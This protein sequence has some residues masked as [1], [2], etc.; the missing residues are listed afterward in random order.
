[1][2]DEKDE[3]KPGENPQIDKV[4]KAYL[5]LGEESLATDTCIAAL[6][7]MSTSDRSKADRMINM[8][9]YWL[10]K[11][12]ALVRMLTMQMRLF[13]NVPAVSLE[14]FSLDHPP[15][16]AI[17]RRANQSDVYQIIIENMPIVDTRMPWA[18]VMAFRNDPTSKQQLR[19][20]R[21]WIH[22][23]L[24]SKI[25]YLELKERIE[26]LLEA[27][28]QHLKG[29]GIKNGTSILKAFVVGSAEIAEAVIKLR[30]KTLAEMP[31]K[32]FEARTELVEAERN[33]PGRE[34][35]YIV[36]ATHE[37]S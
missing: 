11:D 31:F 12:A 26:F 19:E 23:V 24:D 25:T 28:R 30:L 14:T 20:L 9:R 33:A 35:A 8:F 4:L 18:E 17:D 3:L 6:D 16:N 13:E 32:I 34:L 2:E 37:F 27:Y 22:G 21:L 10:L 29:A 5:Q 1:M 36:R 15:A 7:A